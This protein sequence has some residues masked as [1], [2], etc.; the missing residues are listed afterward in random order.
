MVLQDFDHCACL[1]G[2][3]SS[4]VL[5]QDC[6]AAF[7]GREALRVLVLSGAACDGPLG[8]CSLA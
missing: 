3:A 1:G 8:Q 2:V 5:N 6:V 4:L 7:E